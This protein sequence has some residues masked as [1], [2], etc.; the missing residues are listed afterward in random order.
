MPVGPQLIDDSESEHS[1][2]G[3][4]SQDSQVFDFEG[5]ETPTQQS[6][7][8]IPSGKCVDWSQWK[9]YHEIIRVYARVFSAI[10]CF[11]EK[12]VCTHIKSFNEDMLKTLTALNFAKAKR[13][14]I[15]QMQ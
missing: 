6:H 3:F 15:Q 7:A 11:K 14:L 1:F 12:K 13:Y 2:H 5:F 8:K 4:E 9:S 10:D